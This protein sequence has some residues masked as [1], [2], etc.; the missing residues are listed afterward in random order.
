[1]R[2]KYQTYIMY[3]DCEVS[4]VYYWDD[5]LQ[6]EY[7][8]TSK[9]FWILRMFWSDCCY[10]VIKGYD[11]ILRMLSLNKSNKQRTTARRFHHTIDDI[12]DV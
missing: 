9:P 10:L 1:M 7:V 11:N 12:Y 2:P 3:I 6:F 4:K 8:L 5:C